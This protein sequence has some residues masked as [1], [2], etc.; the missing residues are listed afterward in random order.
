L[1]FIG[2]VLMEN[3]GGLVDAEALAAQG[4]HRTVRP[5]VRTKLKDEIH[6]VLTTLVPRLTLLRDSKDVISAEFANRKSLY[7]GL[8]E[9]YEFADRLPSSWKKLQGLD[10]WWERHVSTGQDDAG[11]AYARRSKVERGWEVLISHKGEQTRD[12][13]W[14]ERQ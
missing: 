13:L 9:L 6:V 12:I 7:R 11:R 14:L 5:V 10:Q 3:R 2:H 1:C 4:S 8:A